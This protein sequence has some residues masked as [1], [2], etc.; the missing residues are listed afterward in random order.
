MATEQEHVWSGS[1]KGSVVSALVIISS[2]II[3]IALVEIG[4]RFTQY[5]YILV[6]PSYGIPS[7][8]YVKDSDLG[9]K[10]AIDYPP[11]EHSFAGPPYNIFSNELGCFDYPLAQPASGIA[12][13]D[14]WTWGFAAL[15]NKWTSIV[16]R[17]NEERLLKCGVSG[18]GT[19]H[20][21]KT[22]R[23]LIAQ[24]VQAKYV[25]MLYT[26]NDWVDDFA[27]NDSTVYQGD[28]VSKIKG[29]N[30][31][32]GNIDF[33]TMDEIATSW[34]NK[35]RQEEKSDKKS[36][37]I[38]VEMYKKYLK[39]LLSGEKVEN[40]RKKDILS[41]DY[42]HGKYAINLWY[43][44]TRLA[45]ENRLGE[46]EWILRSLGNHIGNIE[47]LSQFCAENDLK[48]FM[49]DYSGELGSDEL[50]LALLEKLSE[51]KHA[52]Y[53]DLKPELEKANTSNRRVR[54]LYDGHWNDYGNRIAGE[55][56]ADFI[57]K[58]M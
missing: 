51:Q 33:R 46:R 52:H 31:V 10:I 55:V 53:L 2:F 47:A 38:V 34:S 18:T 22:L 14:S 23:R 28:R 36:A 21:F 11:T 8:Y 49:V 9:F 35:K 50:G 41:R 13:G 1:L 30:L 24:G 32:N 25:V 4:L 17:V 6:E 37:F 26:R 40:K 19:L 3:S 58:R 16:E 42:I 7:G 5:Q 48:F 29:I 15:E 54:W 20:Q 43:L 56:I 27:F 39:P 45:E 44:K 57:S 12:I